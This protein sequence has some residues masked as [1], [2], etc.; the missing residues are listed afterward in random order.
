MVKRPPSITHTWLLYRVSPGA[1]TAFSI[2]DGQSATLEPSPNSRFAQQGLTLFQ[3]DSL[4]AV[5]PGNTRGCMT[6]KQMT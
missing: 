6:S 3:C 2:R 1:L 4:G 5:L